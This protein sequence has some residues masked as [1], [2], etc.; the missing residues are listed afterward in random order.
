MTDPG[1]LP[2]RGSSG[3]SPAVATD[4]RNPT[5]PSAHWLS[6]PR[7]GD[8]AA[9]FAGCLT[10]LAFAPFNLYPLALLAP[11]LLFLVWRGE[12]AG[13]A[14]WRGFL[15][16]LGSF[17]IGVS[18]VYVSMHDFGFMPVPLAGLATLLFVAA[19]ALYPALFG[20]LQARLS[21]LPTGMHLGIALPAAWVLIEWWRGW[22]LTGFPWL[23][24]GYSQSDTV[25]AGYA[26]VLGVYGVSLATAASA[27]LLA[28]LLCDRA[29][30]MWLYVPALIVVWLGGWALGNIDWTQPSGAPLRVALAQGNVELAQKWHPD[31][32]QAIVDR[33]VHLSEQAG[34][35]DLVVWPEAALPGYLEQFGPTLMPRLEQLSSALGAELM[36]G[37]VERDVGTRRYYNS[38]LRIGATPAWYRK[39][40]LVPFG[41]FLPWP[42]VFR[43]LI[44][45]L[46]IPM[47]DF[48]AGTAA[49]PPFRAAG[50]TLGVSICYEDA[51][52]EEM[53]RALPAATLLVNVSE[54]A[55]FGNSLAPHQ[56]VQMARLR[57]REAG[58]PLVRAANTGPSVAIDHVGQVTAR[59]PQ[60]EPHLLVAAVQ[61]M[62]GV[63]PYARL[64][65]GPAIG[66]ALAFLLSVVV[67][68]RRAHA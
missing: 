54:D 37:V 38:V 9:L 28:A 10:P 35:A 57:A 16:G 49:Q 21:A 12:S 45:H 53:I 26:P 42:A 34:K 51:F 64:A 67:A 50:H 65:N 56:R 15:Y 60:F 66:L 14:A 3:E 43:G 19:L 58:R 32:R 25:L 40:H 33:Y 48:S 29:R 47:S 59:S 5:V 61:P 30:V 7:H 2:P 24:L 41:E 13:R 39:Q 44:Q 1:R 6:R 52:G 27:G 18:W 23:N 36:L 20:L 68:A 63:T 11:A 46:Q 62:Q 22:F 4:R 17:G 55:W 8:A 31:Y